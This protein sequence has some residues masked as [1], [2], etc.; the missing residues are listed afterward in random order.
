MLFPENIGPNL[1]IDE[2]SLSPGEI[3]HSWAHNAIGIVLKIAT[4]LN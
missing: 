1:S 2:V 3:W 4:L